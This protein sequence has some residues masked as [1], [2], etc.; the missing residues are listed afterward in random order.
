MTFYTE[1]GTVEDF[2]I[3]ELQRLGQATITLS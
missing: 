2:I 3:Q 1:K